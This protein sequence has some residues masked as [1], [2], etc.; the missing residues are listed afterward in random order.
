MNE[1]LIIKP[2]P[3]PQ[4]AFCASSADLSIY[5]GGAGGG[6]TFALLIKR[7]RH[8]SNPDFGAVIFRRTRP[9]ITNEGG[10]WDESE[11]LYS[12]LRAMPNQARLSW[13]F[14][15]GAKIQLAQM[16]YDKDRLRWQG[17]QIPDL[18]FDE[19]THFS[20]KQFNYML[21]RNRSTCGV[22]P[23]IDLTCNP[24]PDHWLAEMLMDYFVDPDSG[25]P[26][27]ERAGRLR[28]FLVSEDRI[29]QGQDRVALEK[30]YK[31]PAKSFTFIPALVTDNQ[32]LLKQNPEYLANLE[33]LDKV[34]RARLLKG[35][36]KIRYSAGML[37]KRA[38]YEMVRVAPACTRFVRA[39]DLAA[40][41]PSPSNPDPDWTVGLKMGLTE[42]KKRYIDDIARFRATPGKRDTMIRNI[43]LQDG[44][45]CLQVFYRDPGAAGKSQKY[46]TGSQLAGLPLKFVD[47]IHDKITKAHFFSAQSEIG[48]IL[49]K[50]APW[51]E[52]F[53]AEMEQFPEG[54]HDDQSDTA[55]LAER[56]L[57]EIGL[58]GARSL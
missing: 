22:S 45:E 6:K 5:G 43:A 2:Q 49:V 54:N 24:D 17:S 4:E 53:F 39:W 40:T 25:F 27:P 33:N 11:K 47:D 13:K 21:S 23:T 50:I 30:K 31:K 15:S 8:I 46:Y 44:P 14:P 20:W 56:V 18:S 42:I 41:E 55:S 32:I 57:T 3:G 48:N 29:I 51:N 36:W 12:P 34:Q 19:A 1:P 38:W 52:P 28:Y 16:Q 10:L 58:A 7:L 35:N 26:V 9:E 37:F